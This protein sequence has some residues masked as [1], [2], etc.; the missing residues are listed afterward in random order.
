VNTMGLSVSLLTEKYHFRVGGYSY[1]NMFREALAE[2]VGVNLSE[3]QGYGGMKTWDDEP[4]AELLRHSDCDGELRQ[5]ECEELDKDFS[6]EHKQLLDERFHN[7]YD[8]WW[9]II[10]DCVQEEGVILFH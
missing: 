8:D 9:S 1:F 10:I 2:S 7:D 5:D 3:M 4:Y 6:E